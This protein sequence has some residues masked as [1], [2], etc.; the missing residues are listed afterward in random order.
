M[1]PG[2]TTHLSGHGRKQKRTLST[3]VSPW[4][5]SDT[6]SELQM[7]G[8]L[9]NTPKIWFL[10][11]RFLR[12]SLKSQHSLR[13]YTPKQTGDRSSDPWIRRDLSHP[14][15]GNLELANFPTSPCYAILMLH[16]IAPCTINCLT[17]FIS[18]QVNKLQHAVPVQQ[19]YIKL[20]LTT[21][22]ITYP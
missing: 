6:Y 11:I 9:M 10:G 7:S 1:T 2:F 20:Q 8:I 19:G 21:E 22:N 5:I 3:P 14:G 13:D 16:M 18:A 4:E 17:C 15:N 12:I